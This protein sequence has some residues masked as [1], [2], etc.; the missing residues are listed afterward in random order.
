MRF[1]LAVLV[2]CLSLA[3]GC[4][5]CGPA[6]TQDIKGCTLDDGRFLNVG[7]SATVSCNDCVC[8]IDFSLRCTERA[9][10]DAGP[11]QADA[12]PPADAGTPEDAGVDAGVVDE[13]PCHD[14]DGDGFYDC[15]DPDH[16]ERPQVVDC[17]DERFHVQPGGI[18]FA[19]TPEDDNCN[20][21]NDDFDTCDCGG[22]ASN[23]ADL[24]SGMDICGDTVTSATKNGGAI[25]FG[26]VDAYRGVI[27]PRRRARQDDPDRPP[28][29]I[30]NNCLATLSSG[31]A[32]GTQTGVD[33]D[34]GFCNFSDPDPAH[35]DP[36]PTICD[37]AQLHFTLHVPPNAKGFAFDFM[38][39]SQEWPEYLCLVYNDTFYAIV[40]GDDA[41]NQGVAT[42]AAFDF[43]NRPITV[44]VGFFE[45]PAQ[46]TVPLDG[47]PYGE[48]DSFVSC[49]SPG[50][51]DF[52]DGC[53]LPTYCSDPNL[54]VRTGSG[55]GWLT[56]SVPAT[57][58]ETI[59]LTLSIHDEFDGF[60]DSLVLLDAF[61]W[62]PF[63]PELQT[64]KE[65][66]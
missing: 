19:D 6:S 13:G 56:T 41:V 47:T 17:D 58:G 39:M 18:E 44:N 35:A 24:G 8:S 59:T 61:R 49:P 65:E 15:I 55:S 27:G 28:V 7:E 54:D 36:N 14:S 20:G 2:S 12:G 23:A 42:N 33:V 31:D 46:W 22:S 9:C 64:A 45:D 3:V 60:F 50:D 52:Q 53:R 16:P 32:T 1:A 51:L 34:G 5:G 11:G 66:P 4:E 38:F 10:D 37:L 21:R 30:G 57:P 63:E 48:S 43:A 25:Q 40:D 26:V 62:L 29:I